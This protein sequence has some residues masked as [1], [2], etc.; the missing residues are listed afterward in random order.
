MPFL[1]R[2]TT[3]ILGATGCML[4]LL[5]GS[6][7]A[8]VGTAQSDS[9][10]DFEL[11]VGVNWTDNLGREPEGESET[12]GSLGTTVEFARESTRVRSSL[13]GE[14]DYYHY[15]SDRFDNEVLGRID[16]VLGLALVPQRL[17]WMIE[18]R[19][20]QVR[21]DPFAADRPENREYL[22]VFETGPELYLPLGERTVLGASARYADRRWQDSDE[23]DS[24]I[25]SG[26]V[27]IVRLLSPTQQ[28]GLVGGM[29]SIEYDGEGIP[30]YEVYSAYLSY[31]RT[32][33]TGE[34]GLDVGANRLNIAGRTDT[35]LLLRANWTREL[36]A[37]SSLAL[38]VGREFQDAGDQLRGESL[39]ETGFG[40]GEGALTGD[41]YVYTFGMATYTLTRERTTIVLGGEWNRERYDSVSALD[42]DV[43]AARASLAYRL[44]PALTG[45]VSVTLRREDFDTLDGATA[46]ELTAGAALIR[47]LG[48]DFDL[49]LEYLYAE[50]DADIG[51]DFE[52]NRVQL[53]LIWSPGRG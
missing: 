19:F 27:R 39:A 15:D 5:A 44:S 42:R 48:R 20:G 34:V 22:N 6:A 13:R 52:E 33:A 37:R 51:L 10:L 26:Q 21:T 50:R 31:A 38:A 40:G 41:P 53:L 2:C 1:S 30:R 16:G 18:N 11:R 49:R 14:L 36:T 7:H 17:D 47:R 24:E 4:G 29:R 9:E 3:S 8:Q 28:L 35:G 25:Q 46:D 12:F 32:L 43:L 45:E 23:L